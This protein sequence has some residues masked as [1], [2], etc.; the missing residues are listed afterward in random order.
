[1]TL[2]GERKIS[3]GMATVVFGM[4]F[5]LSVP[6]A[7]TALA[8]HSYPKIPLR[9]TIDMLLRTLI[10]AL[11]FCLGLCT[12]GYFKKQSWAKRYTI[13]AAVMLGVITICILLEATM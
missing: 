11:P 6:L 7:Y 13:Y 12:W 4:L 8:C 3:Q 1:M 2:S 9:F 5:V 10:I